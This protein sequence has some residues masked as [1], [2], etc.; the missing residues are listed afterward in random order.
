MEEATT[1]TTTE[2]LPGVVLTTAV[3]TDDSSVEKVDGGTVENDLAAS[4]DDDDD[5]V[6]MNDSPSD[7]SNIK[8]ND[9]MQVEKESLKE[10]GPIQKKSN[11]YSDEELEQAMKDLDGKLI[12][13][14]N[15]DYAAAW[16]Q[17][18]VLDVDKLIDLLQ[19]S[20]SAGD[21]I[22]GK[23][24]LLLI[25]GTGAG[26]VSTLNALCCMNLIFLLGNLLLILRLR[27]PFCL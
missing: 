14:G 27:Y 22:A 16:K 3:S 11:D 9:A 4:K 12:L 10:D 25:G 21:V 5:D 17:Q 7:E 1:T 24:V 23:D 26:K 19:A 2:A 18:D 20:K 15:H 8:D 6:E 13:D